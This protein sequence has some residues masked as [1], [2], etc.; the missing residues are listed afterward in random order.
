MGIYSTQTEKKLAIKKDLI[1]LQS[2]VDEI[3]TIVDQGSYSDE[4]MTLVE[5]LSEL[6]DQLD[7]S[8][9]QGVGLIL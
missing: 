8:N 7:M 2:I 5:K 3:E 1:K 9:N 4:I 6:H